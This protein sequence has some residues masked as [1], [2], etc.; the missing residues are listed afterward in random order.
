MTFAGDARFDGAAFNDGA[1]FD[2]ATFDGEARFEGT[3]L[4]GDLTFDPWRR[5]K[6]PDLQDNARSAGDGSHP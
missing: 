2:A 3:K 6:N 5:W 4:S 1:Q